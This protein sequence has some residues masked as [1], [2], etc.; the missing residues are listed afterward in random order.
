MNARFRTKVTSLIAGLF[1]MTA[2]FVQ[3]DAQNWKPNSKA[4]DFSGKAS[5]G[6]TYALKT[7]LKSKKP[8]IIYCIGNTCPVN[9]QAVKYYN[10]IANAYKGKVNFIG[11]ID[12][13]EAG[14]KE[15]Q[16]RFNAPYP[17][18]FDP[19]LKIISAYKAE[20]SPWSFMVDNKGLIVQEW[21]GYSIGEL[22]EMG[23]AIA[24]SNKIKTVKFDVKGAPEQPRYG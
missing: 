10:N 15:W 20:R 9:A 22:N 8:T 3:A 12:T 13:D 2:F 1:L 16:K 24:K 6:K 18:V 21:P 11:V 5:D 23:S 14:Y 17:V 4:P 7:L 19:E